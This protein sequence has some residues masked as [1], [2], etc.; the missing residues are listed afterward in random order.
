[1]NLLHEILGY[2]ENKPYGNIMNNFHKLWEQLNNLDRDAKIF[3]DESIY[4]EKEELEEDLLM[5]M[6]NIVGRRVKTDDITFSLYFSRKNASRHAIRVKV[7][8]DRQ[9]I[10]ED[11]CGYMELHGDYRYSQSPTQKY[12]PKAYMVDTLRYFIK[13]YKVLFAAV[14]EGALSEDS[15]QEYFRGGIDFKEL[16]SEFLVN[17][18]GKQKYEAL[19][20]AENLKQLEQL[21][22]QY[23]IFNMND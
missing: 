10:S 4:G 14:W 22:R 21:V 9:N 15:L 17:K 18:V 13:K 7:Y 6:A 16:L 20:Y 11:K 3:Y 2:H 1:M 12:K 8:W 5:E 19:N 23:K